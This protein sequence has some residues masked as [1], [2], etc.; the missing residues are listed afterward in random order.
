MEKQL[1]SQSDLATYSPAAL[2]AWQI[3]FITTTVSQLQSF[4]DEKI[5]WFSVDKSYF[6]KIFG[7]NS[8]FLFEVKISLDDIEKN[9]NRK[10][11]VEEIKKLRNKEI[12]YEI[13][14]GGEEIKRVNCP[15]ISS[16]YEYHNGQL[17]VGISVDALRWLLYYGGNI[18][19]T[20]YDKKSLLEI[21]GRYSKGIF[22]LLSKYYRNIIKKI[23]I[24]DLMKYLNTPNYSVQKFEEKILEKAFF[25]INGNPNN[26]L[27]FKYNLIW[28]DDGNYKGG[29]KGF[30]TVILKIYD[31]TNPKSKHA[32]QHDDFVD[33][34]ICRGKC[35]LK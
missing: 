14:L 24:S 2:S 1:I 7:L 8:G 13:P 32:F 28:E 6:T 31:M 23:P 18:G 20:T 11:V 3:N 4:L 15:I 26:R 17:S 5:D 22:L 33:R 34:I 29:K 10:K 35:T 25:E 9:Q 30:N 12:I 19:L 27:F 21:K 16:I